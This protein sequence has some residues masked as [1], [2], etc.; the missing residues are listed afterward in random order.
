MTG[1]EWYTYLG[2]RDC[3]ARFALLLSRLNPP[4]S[5]LSTGSPEPAR[6]PHLAEL[7]SAVNILLICVGPRLLVF[8][9]GAR[10]YTGFSGITKL[11]IHIFWLLIW[12]VVSFLCRVYSSTDSGLFCQ[13]VLGQEAKPSRSESDH[14]S[15]R[16]S[17]SQ[18]APLSRTRSSSARLSRPT[19]PRKTAC[20]RLPGTP[21]SAAWREFTRRTCRARDFSHTSRPTVCV[22]ETELAPSAFAVFV[23][24]ENIAYNQG[25]DDPGAFAVE[26][27]MLSFEASR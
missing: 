24:G 17:V 20:R 6:A 2:R 9:D 23:L 22:C 14:V 1:N 16:F 3:R 18:L 7:A 25:Y 26:R 11:L 27:W 12:V 5:A 13:S 8:Y 19:R 15:R 21:M 10:L 4:G